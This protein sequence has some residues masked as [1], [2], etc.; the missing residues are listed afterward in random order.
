M[1]QLLEIDN[2]AFAKRTYIFY[3]KNLLQNC[4]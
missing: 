2:K 1:Y 3:R 4:I